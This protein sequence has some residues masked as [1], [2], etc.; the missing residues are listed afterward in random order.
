M[1]T[2]LR[3]PSVPLVTIDPYTSCWSPSQLLAAEWPQHWTGRAHAMSGFIRVDGKA[4][5]FLGAAP[6]V[7]QQAR[8]IS[9]DVQATQTIYQFAAGPVHLTVTFTAPLLLDDLELLSRPANYVTFTVRSSDGQPH[10][11]QLYL[12][13]TAEWCVNDIRQHVTWGRPQIDGLDVLRIGT[14]DQ[15]VLKI[16]GDNV[17]IDWGYLYLAVPAGT[18]RTAIAADTVA[19]ESF[20]QN[21]PLPD[22]DDTDKPRMVRDRWPVLAVTFDLPQVT[23]EPVSRH[24]IVAYDDLFSVEYFGQPLR[25]WWRRGE[26]ASAE[27]MLAAAERDY[28]EVMKRCETFNRELDQ[29]TR[30]AGGDE[31]AALCRLV[32]RQAI[33]AHKLVA[34]PQGKPLFFS[35]ENFSNGSIGTVDV[36]Y[37]ST[38]LFLAYNPVF[39]RG[40]ME[41]IFYYAES[42]RWDKPFAAHDVGTYPLANG[43]TYPEDMPVEECGNMLILAAAVAKAEGNADYAGSHWQ[44][45]TRWAEYLK[46]EGFDPANQLCTD[47]FAGHLAY[48]ANLSIK[49]ILGLASY[50]ELAKQLGHEQAAKE[51][52]ALAKELAGK[53]LERADDG[54]HTRLT[55][56]RPGTWSQKYNLVWDRLLGYELFPPELAQQEIA[57]YLTKQ[58]EYGLPLDSRKTYTKSDW[59]IWTASMADSQ[60]DFL[61][62]MLPVYRYVNETP[63]RVPVS[64][65][66]ETTNGKMVGFQARSVVGGYFMKLLAD[67]WRKK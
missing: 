47:D 3:P 67:R 46:N 56:D 9:L 49:A 33:A 7:T 29:A 65:W 60:D 28:P 25:A 52:S 64:D 53:W 26:G 38:P 22:K 4:Y 16:K 17:R 19:R 36:T 11:V 24:V 34:D 40:M 35:K 13:A 10:D 37:P 12:D 45:L 42:G 59:I 15:K 54:D 23:A 31:Y 1:E 51:Y 8:Q 32:Y 30:A 58:N 21:Q 63:S 20:A 50:G 43:Q 14:V 57:Y 61:A 27:A 39:V 18:A 6:Q 5:R 55:F 44:T 2:T 41:P 62:L 48:N 66:H